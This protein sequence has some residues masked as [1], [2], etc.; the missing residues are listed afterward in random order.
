MPGAQMA[1]EGDEV[2]NF[3][4]RNQDNREIHIK[5]YRGKTLLL[6]FIYTRC[7]VPDYCVTV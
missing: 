7:H 1:K 4:L 2:P 3:T 6:T 5:D